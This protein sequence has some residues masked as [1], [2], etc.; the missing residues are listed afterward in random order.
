MLFSALSLSFVI[1]KGMLTSQI[2]GIDDVFEI[3]VSLLFA[4]F[5]H[6]IIASTVTL[7]NLAG[8]HNLVL[9]VI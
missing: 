6:L 4:L 5:N 8:S 9:R 3:I 2:V 7:V 1:V